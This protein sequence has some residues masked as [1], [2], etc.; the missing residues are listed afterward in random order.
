[1][2]G[3]ALWPGGRELSWALRTRLRC[4]RSFRRATEL[5][6]SRDREHRIIH[7]DHGTG[8]GYTVTG[9]RGDWEKYGFFPLGL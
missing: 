3:C 8:R 6:M 7:A 2:H 9:D 1:M 5:N 4:A